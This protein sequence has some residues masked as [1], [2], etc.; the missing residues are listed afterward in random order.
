MPRLSIVFIRLSLLYLITGIG[1]GGFLLLQKGSPY[2]FSVWFL[3]QVHIEAMAVGW[4][5]QFVIGVSYWMLPR[6][7]EPPL[8]GNETPVWL[9]LVFLNLG[10]VLISA[11]HLF[12]LSQVLG[13]CGRLLETAAVISY[14]FNIWPRVKPFAAP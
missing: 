4:V 9:T 1:I 14:V 12:N 6:F 3:S 2:S 11:E 7:A 13:M 5:L 10:V 8:R